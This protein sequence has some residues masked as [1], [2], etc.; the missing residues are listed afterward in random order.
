MPFR[1]GLAALA[2][3]ACGYV[4]GELSSRTGDGGPDAIDAR[5]ID[6]PPP[7]PYVY[8]VS[9]QSLY[10]IDVDNGDAMFVGTV[11]DGSTQFSIDALAYD[12]AVLYG[13]P[14]SHDRWLRINPA[15]GQVLTNTALGPTR[16]YWGLTLAPAGE[17][18]PSAVLFAASNGSGETGGGRLYVV[19]P[20]QG[21]ATPRPSPFGSNM[22]IEGDI[23]WVRDQGLFGSFLGGTCAPLCIG[24]IDHVTGVASVLKAN[25]VSAL[26]GLS[27]FRDQLWAFDG[28]GNVFN[29]DMVTGQTTLVSNADS[30]NWYDNAQ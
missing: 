11:T 22:T 9:A 17:A 7:L 27:G 13:I 15:N 14:S 23:A 3:S 29:V 30:I 1:L 28:S 18:G 10:Q 6:A 26:H 12:G 4:H 21:T 24:K 8:G 5:M 16:G 25:A 20:S 2:V 19:D